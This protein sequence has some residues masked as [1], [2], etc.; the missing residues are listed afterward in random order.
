M[1]LLIFV[2]LFMGCTPQEPEMLLGG[3]DDPEAIP[4]IIP[5][6]QPFVNEGCNTAWDNLSAIVD[7]EGNVTYFEDLPEYTSDPFDYD[8]S[9]F[10]FVYQARN[11]WYGVY[12]DEN[13][14]ARMQT[15]WKMLPIDDYGVLTCQGLQELR[16]WILD[17]NTDRWYMN[18]QVVLA[19]LLCNGQ[20]DCDQGYGFAEIE[21]VQYEP[22]YLYLQ[23][24]V[25]TEQ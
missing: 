20:D 6:V 25:M 7:A 15:G 5:A 24:G 19:S 9:R 17:E 10:T 22:G 3:P 2:L 18:S 1:R 14:Y 21:F 11:P 4:D 13:P 12:E 23:D 16:T 8:K